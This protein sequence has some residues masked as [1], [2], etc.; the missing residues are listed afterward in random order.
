MGRQEYE[1]MLIPAYKELGTVLESEFWH[2]LVPIFPILAFHIHSGIIPLT[3]PLPKK[4]IHKY[5]QYVKV[6]IFIIIIIMVSPNGSA[7]TIVNNDFQLYK[8]TSKTML[9]LGCVWTDEGIEGTEI[10]RGQ[11]G[12]IRLRLCDDPMAIQPETLHDKPTPQR[13]PKEWFTNANQTLP[14]AK[15]SK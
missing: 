8:A 11:F 3:H 2:K 9:A 10:V 1:S 4:K 6:P 12:G 5:I 15:Y 7:S 13:P 14:T